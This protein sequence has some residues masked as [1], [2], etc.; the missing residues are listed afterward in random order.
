MHTGTEPEINY[1]Y[2]LIVRIKSGRI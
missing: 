1:W 2:I